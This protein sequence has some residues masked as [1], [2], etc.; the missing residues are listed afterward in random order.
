MAETRL[1]A[2]DLAKTL[3][4]S[5][6]TVGRMLHE[7]RLPAPCTGPKR[8]NVEWDRGAIAEWLRT[9]DAVR[10]TERAME[11][12]ADCE[13]LDPLLRSIA[14]TAR[15]RLASMEFPI[16]VRRNLADVLNKV[17]W[18]RGTEPLSTED[19]RRVRSLLLQLLALTI[20]EP[21]K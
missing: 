18:E 17:R 13:E 15:R 16:G 2:A 14:K 4:V 3:G 19:R 1:T 5:R 9:F 12:F 6:S 20:E 21:G 10:S 7:G 8:R 11:Q